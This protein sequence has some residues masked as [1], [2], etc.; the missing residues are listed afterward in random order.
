MSATL[1][2]LY[3]PDDLAPELQVQLSENQGHY[4]THVLRLGEASPF[5]AF[6]GRDGEWECR[7]TPIGKK[8][9]QARVERQ[10]RPQT[11]PGRIDFYFA[12]LKQARLDYLIQ[13]A[14]EL[15]AARIGPVITAR[16]I[17]AKASADRMRSNAIE[18]AEQCGILSIPEIR[19]A[20]KLPSLLSSWPPDH[21]LIYC[22]EKAAIAS[23]LAALNG[24]QH[25][26]Y[27]VLVGPEGGFT[28]EETAKLRKQSFVTAISLGPRIMRADT[29]A[30]AALSLVNAVL[31]DWR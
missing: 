28:D 1:P 11:E 5:L 23:P 21:A 13:K 30:V 9:V 8:K 25:D 2:R 24:L 10:T 3:L 26:R 4:L 22:D 6:N 29:A 7:L 18:A 31:G 19:P 17:A 20:V 15:G 16:T 27:A 12:P 14:V